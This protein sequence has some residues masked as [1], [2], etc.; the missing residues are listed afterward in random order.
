[1]VGNYRE[2]VG[3]RTREGNDDVLNYAESCIKGQ[4]GCSFIAWCSVVSSSLVLFFF[5]WKGKRS[6]MIW[7]F[8][9]KSQAHWKRT[10]MC[11]SRWHHAQDP[12]YAPSMWP[13]Q[14]TPQ[15][16]NGHIIASSLPWTNETS[17]IV[18]D[19]CGT[20]CRS[21]RGKG[22]K[23]KKGGGVNLWN[24]VFS[25]ERARTHSFLPSADVTE[26]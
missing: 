16:V 4:E 14:V 19:Q 6:Y 24:D 13:C 22:R 23:R 10:W 11:D 8:V 15:D 21:S 17:N 3:P 12:G 18:H 1:M 2:Q 7:M 20:F 5:S 25:L 26:E 9:P